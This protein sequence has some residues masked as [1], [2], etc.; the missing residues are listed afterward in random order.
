MNSTA[1]K[2]YQLCCKY[3]KEHTQRINRRIAQ[4]WCFSVANRVCVCQCGRVGIRTCYRT[5]NGEIVELVFHSCNCSNNE[6][7]NNRNQEAC[8]NILQAIALYY[9]FPEACTSLDT[10]RCQ[11]QCQTYFAQHH[12]SRCRGIG[13]KFHMITETTEKNGDD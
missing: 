1:E 11:E 8:V 5:H 6:D 9:G 2:N 12:I 13:N 3:S 7:W 4:S 10:N